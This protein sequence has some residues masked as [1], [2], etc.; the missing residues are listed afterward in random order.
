MG[1]ERGVCYSVCI[2]GSGAYLDPDKFFPE[3]DSTRSSSREGLFEKVIERLKKSGAEIKKD[4]EYPYYRELSNGTE[5]ETGTE[6]IVEFVRGDEEWQISRVVEVARVKGRSVEKMEK[7]EV[8]I[9]V[10]KR[11]IDTERWEI[12]D[13]SSLA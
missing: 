5:E 6:R 12:V 2:M 11:P 3:T 1:V 9:N 7:E 8:K 13:L 10:K 4:E